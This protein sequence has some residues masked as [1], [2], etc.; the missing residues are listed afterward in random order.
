MK[1]VEELVCEYCEI[2]HGIYEK[3]VS[4]S[5]FTQ[6]YLANPG[7]KYFK[8]IMKQKDKE[9]GEWSSSAS[10][11]AFVEKKT[12]NVLMASS[13]NAPAKNGVRY[14]LFNDLEYIKDNA[15]WAGSYLYK[16]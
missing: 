9:T 16:R 7:N 1:T 8:I 13:Y 10:V 14:N 4:N 2:L 5:F 3:T 12:G 6:Y 11:H 15:D